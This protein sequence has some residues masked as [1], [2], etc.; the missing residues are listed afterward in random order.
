MKL[1]LLLLPLASVAVQT[2]KVVPN[3]K[4]LPEAGTQ[5]TEGF[6]SQASVAVAR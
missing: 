6:V 3:A 5:T 4:K 1:Q 2:T